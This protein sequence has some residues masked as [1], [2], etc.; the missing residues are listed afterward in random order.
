MLV[1]GFLLWKGRLFES[2]P[3]LWVLM[4]AAP[5]PYIANTF[6]WMT[7]ELGRQPFLVYGL[8]R[9]ADGSSQVVSA[10]NTIFTLLGFMG[11]YTVLSI[12]FLFLVRREVEHGPEPETAVHSAATTAVTI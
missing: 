7:T 12:L 8:L 2:R 1:S 4:L 6:G 11:L 5:F 9:T 10:G 3:I